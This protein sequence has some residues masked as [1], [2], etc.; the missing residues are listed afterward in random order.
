[1]CVVA[2]GGYNGN[3][4]TVQPTAAQLACIH[5]RLRTGQPMNRGSIRGRGK[6]FHFS[7][8]FSRQALRPAKSPTE[9]IPGK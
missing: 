4:F 7:S 5:A 2:V 1:M 8:E 6:R 9:W 3:S